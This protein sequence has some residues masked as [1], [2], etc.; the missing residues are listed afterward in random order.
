MFA[1]TPTCSLP[2]VVV[3]VFIFPL[4]EGRAPS[5]PTRARPRQAGPSHVR[6]GS[7]VARRSPGGPRSVAADSRAQNFKTTSTTPA[8]QLAVRPSQQSVRAC[9]RALRPVRCPLLSMLFSFS[10]LREGRAPSRPHAHYAPAA[11]RR[12][13]SGMARS[14]QTP[15]QWSSDVA[16]IDSQTMSAASE[17]ASCMPNPRMRAPAKTEA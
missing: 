11:M 6:W 5:R 12:T 4:R 1:S 2:P 8:N 13:S 14:K 15:Y 16:L 17:A 7:R 9:S 10:P 3:V